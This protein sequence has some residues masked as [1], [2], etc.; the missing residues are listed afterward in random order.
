MAAD[1]FSGAG[2]PPPAKISSPGG[3]GGK[4]PR[5]GFSEKVQGKDKQ[6][7]KP[8]MYDRRVFA[9]KLNPGE[10][11]RQILIL[12]PPGKE[13]RFSLYLHEFTAPDG[14]F[15][16][17]LASIH[18]QDPQGDPLNEALG[19]EPGWAWALTGIDLQR[20]TNTEKPDVVYGFK[21][22]LVL[23]RDRQKE[24]FLTM[25]KMGD[26][27]R[28]RIFKVSRESDK[29]SPK[30]GTS[31]DPIERLSEDQMRE[32]FAS[33]AEQYGI[34]IEKFVAPFNYREM[35]KPFSR[36]QLVQIANEITEW[37]KSKEGVQVAT[38]DDEAIPF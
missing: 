33:D 23:V 30:I 20:Y 13:N 14:R 32:R 6:T 25:E 7:G 8:T 35:F 26:G 29:Q 9:W 28:G 4:W 19:E 3:G 38:A 36:A 10:S 34:P 37:K 12:D 24:T 27:L 17:R 5:F 15:G 22:T 2:G 11:D 1:D 31:W 21:R 16:S 18:R